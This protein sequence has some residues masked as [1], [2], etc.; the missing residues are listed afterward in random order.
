M[1]LRNALKGFNRISASHILLFAV[2][3]AMAVAEIMLVG[4]NV[5]K[6]LATTVSDP[7]N[8]PTVRLSLLIS[9]FAGLVGIAAFITQLVGVCKSRHFEPLFKAAVAPAVIM[10]LASLVLFY[11]E[12]ADVRSMSPVLSAVLKPVSNLCLL[13]IVCLIAKG[14]AKANEKIGEKTVAGRQKT[15]LFA[16]VATGIASI[17]CIVLISV[18]GTKTLSDSSLKLLIVLRSVFTCA[19]YLISPVL[20]LPTAKKLRKN[21][22][23][24][25][26]DEIKKDDPS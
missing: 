26:P 8:D 3:A 25:D 18:L 16:A 12:A 23:S 11:L 17:V 19:L 15:A 13:L 1:D 6:S 9:F 22:S 24:L 4:F 14:N 7:L 2:T 5:E 10:L 21:S 20:L